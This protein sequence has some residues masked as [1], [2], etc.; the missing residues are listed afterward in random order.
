[1]QTID[2][3]SQPQLV[4]A[5][6]GELKGRL[7]ELR[8]GTTARMIRVGVSM[9]QLHVL[10]L[11]EH[12]GDVP[13]SRL[14]ELLDVS[15]SNSTGLVDRME[16][17]GLV[18]R[19]RVP[20]DRRLVLVRIGAQG[21]RVLREL[22]DSHLERL[23]RALAHLEPARLRGVLDAFTDFRSAIEADLGPHAEVGPYTHAGRNH[24]I[25]PG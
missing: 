21:L 2:R 25:T 22:D 24:G 1:M 18:E 17:R 3:D 23:Q 5:I 20:D 7:H 12:H 8:C 9:T 4:E 19:V 6:L 14:A 10:W 16:E 11:L 13:M 15:L